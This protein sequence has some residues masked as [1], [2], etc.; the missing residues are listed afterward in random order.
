MKVGQN[1]LANVR[2]EAI[3]IGS[4]DGLAGRVLTRTYLGDKIEYDI[5]VAGQTLQIVRFNPPSSERFAPGEAVTVQL[6]HD[7]VQLL[8][9]GA[10]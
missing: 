2:P 8:A 5:E 6:P 9:K 10:V 1:V 4:G 3:S 7:G